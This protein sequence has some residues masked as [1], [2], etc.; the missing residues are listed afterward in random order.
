M[1]R[2]Q[3]EFKNSRGTHFNIS[4]DTKQKDDIEYLHNQICA[5]GSQVIDYVS[6][7]KKVMNQLGDDY[8]SKVKK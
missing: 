2:R 1:R 8:Y 3:I 6:W 7:F 5:P 4:L